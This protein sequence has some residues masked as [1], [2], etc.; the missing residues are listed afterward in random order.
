MP[1]PEPAD[2]PWG[3]PLGVNCDLGESYGRFRVGDD[4]AVMPY[5][6]TANIA[7][8]Y[9]GGDPSVMRQAAEL[10]A[11]YGVMCGGHPS[12]PDLQGFGRREMD[13]TAGEL[14]DMVLY[15]LG[16][17]K[18]I[19]SAVGVRLT[20][21]KPHGVLYSMLWREE[22]AEAFADAIELVDPALPWI[23][24]EHTPTFDVALR[25]GL[26]PVP[27]FTADRS[28]DASGR[29]IIVRSADPVEIE[30][31]L[32]RVAEVL[33]DKAVT[34]A[35]GSRLPMSAGVVCM[36]GD[37]PNAPEVARALHGLLERRAS[38]LDE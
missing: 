14:K 9:H 19:L 36:H 11:E 18:Q 1:S 10:A 33:E 23:A 3:L 12:L 6:K 29:L 37:G 2:R 25:R 26:R 16:A 30:P 5:I 31:M 13:I 20:H 17:L 28:Y 15:Q 8:G 27:E 22:L 4:A 38:V 34:T 7:C 24:M 21:V 35:E 32:R